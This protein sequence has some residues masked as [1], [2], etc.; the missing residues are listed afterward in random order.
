MNST[1][2]LWGVNIISAFL[3]CLL[4]STLI[5][6][7]I[8]QI[9]Y[10]KQLFDEPNERKLHSTPV[11]RLGGLAFKPLVLLSTVLL[12]AVNLSLGHRELLD[13]LGKDALPF[14]F[15]L[16][17][18][19]LAYLVGIIDDLK[20]VPYR[21]KFVAQTICGLLLVTGG[22]MLTDLNGLAFLHLL[23]SWMSI[24]LSVFAV[25]FIVNA[26]NLIDGI[27]GLASGLC[28]IAFLCYGITFIIYGQ[29]TNALLSFSTAG[30]IIPFYYYNVFGRIE[31]NTKVFMGDT[32]TMTTGIMLCYLS[33]RLTHIADTLPSHVNPFVLAFSPML[34]PCLDVVRVYIYRVCHG[35]NPFLPDKNH[36]HHRLLAMG[37]SQRQAMAI[38]VLAALVLTVLNVS[39]SHRLGATYLLLLDIILWMIANF[40]INV[41][42]KRHNRRTAI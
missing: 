9:A 8:L 20:G 28:I 19:T 34:I 4:L 13:E 26:I 6:P 24:P 5:I 16:C 12:L 7:R 38:L 27:D 29:H 15:T 18:I 11:P 41:R 32:G 35:K 33:I 25:V 1:S 14:T 22:V 40:L 21:S 23:P 42:I 37:L 30:V 3:M 10:R 17:A 31:K 2:I 39:I 36:I